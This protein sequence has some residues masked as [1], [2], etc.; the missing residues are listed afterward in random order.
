MVVLKVESA[1]PA[2]RWSAGRATSF[3]PATA[4]GS[5]CT[6]GPSPAPSRPVARG[7]SLPPVQPCLPLI[8]AR[9]ALS[10]AAAPRRDTASVRVRFDGDGSTRDVDPA[11]HS[12]VLA[13]ATAGAKTTVLRCAWNFLQHSPVK[14]WRFPFGKLSEKRCSQV[15]G[16]V[17]KHKIIE[18]AGLHAAPLPSGLTR[19]G[20]AFSSPAD[21]SASLRPPAAAAAAPP[22]PPWHIDAVAAAGAQPG[23][24]ATDE[25]ASVL[26]ARLSPPS[27][28]LY[29]YKVHM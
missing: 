20:G 3:C 13:P 23:P 12:V 21:T 5:P 28:A 18:C 14:Y 16:A 25:E 10:Q 27:G 4:S 2:G 15:V 9:A 8:G 24:V 19:P 26:P 6:A 11:Q 29:N 1:S 17:A 7:P 22:P